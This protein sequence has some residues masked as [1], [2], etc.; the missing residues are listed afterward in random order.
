[1]QEMVVM[2]ESGKDIVINPILDLVIVAMEEIVVNVLRLVHD[3]VEM[4]EMMESV[5]E[6]GDR[7]VIVVEQEEVQFIRRIL[8]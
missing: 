1:M 6:H 8:P 7:Q 2:E 4:Q 5:E 3:H